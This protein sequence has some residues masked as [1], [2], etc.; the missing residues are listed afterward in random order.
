M[1]LSWFEVVW[2]CGACLCL[3]AGMGLTHRRMQ[4]AHGMRGC[5]CGACLNANERFCGQ[6]GRRAGSNPYGK[7]R[8]SYE[9]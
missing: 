6:C 7:G 5:H 2:L 8:R 9:G 1:D 3:A 4:A